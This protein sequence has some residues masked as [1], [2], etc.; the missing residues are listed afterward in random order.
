MNKFCVCGAKFESEFV[1]LSSVFERGPG[2][3]RPSPLDPRLE[4]HMESNQVSE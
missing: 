3:K 1:S 2:P 4:A